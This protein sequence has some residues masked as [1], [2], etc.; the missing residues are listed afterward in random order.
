MLLII[1]TIFGYD[2][3]SGLLII[4]EP[5]LHLHPQKQKEFLDF[6]EAVSY[7]FRLQIILATHSPLMINEKNIK[8]VYRFHRVGLETKI[9]HPA[10][11]VFYEEAELIHMLK[12]E[13]IAKVFFVDKIIMVE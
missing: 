3:E 11:R 7:D 5:E 6:I 9:D 8:N 2:L 4:D 10:H 12:F 13:N 1:L